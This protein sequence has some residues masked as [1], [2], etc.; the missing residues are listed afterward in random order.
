MNWMV[1]ASM[2]KGFT[3]IELL[4]VIF[5]LAVLAVIAVVSGLGILDD[6]KT[7]LSDIQKETIIDAA[8]NYQLAE[9]KEGFVSLGELSNYG[10]LDSSDLKDPKTKKIIEGGVC[11]TYISEGEE[12]KYKFEYVE[13]EDDCFEYV[14]NE[15]D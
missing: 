6:S 9:N 5:L 8:K 4:A 1:N 13:N 7:T 10:Y 15:D 3:L 14:E 12:N 2:N 11:I